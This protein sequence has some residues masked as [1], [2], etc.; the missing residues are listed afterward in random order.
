MM[1]N[2]EPA[3]S[4]K[5]EYSFA[6][7]LAIR[8]LFTN[9][10]ITKINPQADYIQLGDRVFKGLKPG[11]SEV[12]QQQN[13]LNGIQIPINHYR[14]E[15]ESVT[16]EDVLNNKVDPDNFQGR[17]VVIGVTAREN[18]LGDTWLTPYSAAQSNNHQVYGVT[19]QAQK[20]NQILDAVLN[21]RP[22]FWFLP[23]WGDFL[24]ICAFSLA[25]GLIIWHSP[26]RYRAAVI[27]ASVIVLYG[28]CAFC[29]YKAY[30]YHLFLLLTL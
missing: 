9:H 22:I 5:T 24:V 6:L 26:Q 28:V 2:Q 12:Y 15:V 20:V 29:I 7:Q 1:M 10:K 18:N 3:S 14:N 30:G 27:F 17:I 8:Y 25:S 11:S 16:I 4:C 21:N 23:S 13:N 19:I